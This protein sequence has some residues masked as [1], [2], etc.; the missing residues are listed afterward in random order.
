VTLKQLQGLFVQS[1]IPFWH[2]FVENEPVLDGVQQ[3]F[4][5]DEGVSD[6]VEG[7]VLAEQLHD[8]LDFHLPDAIHE[9]DG[10]IDKLQGLPPLAFEVSSE[11]AF[12]DTVSDLLV[13]FGLFAGALD[14]GMAFVVFGVF[15][16]EGEAE[17]LVIEE[18]EDVVDVCIFRLA[19]LALKVAVAEVH[20]LIYYEPRQKHKGV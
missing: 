5:R 16:D 8:L 2:F 1:A 14:G 6:A 12:E 3:Q 15:G 17:F 10:R 9:P 11:C 4:G 18:G 7:L 20:Q 13:V 19:T